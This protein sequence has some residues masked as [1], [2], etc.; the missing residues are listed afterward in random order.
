QTAEAFNEYLMDYS[1]GE[2]KS[3]TI[4]IASM[5]GEATD[6]EEPSVFEFNIPTTRH[7]RMPG[8]RLEL[9]SIQFGWESYHSAHNTFSGFDIPAPSLIQRLG[10]YCCNREIDFF[11]SSGRPATLYRQAGE[12]YSG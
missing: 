4:K 1:A 12:G 7:R 9:P 2:R 8:V 6:D 3:I 10:L 11:D 5:S